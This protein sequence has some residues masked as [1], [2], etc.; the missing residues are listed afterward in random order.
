MVTALG[1][2][3]SM[4]NVRSRL[5]PDKPSHFIRAWRNYRGLSQEKLGSRIGV[6]HGAISLLE[7]GKIGYTQQTLEALADALQC[8]AADLLWRE[9]GSFFGIIMDEVRQIPPE[10]QERVV[11]I[12]RAF[13]KVA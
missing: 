7:R 3:D 11:A 9:P 5:K 4:S 12:L 1:D 6:T 13:R 2:N 8:E 10:D